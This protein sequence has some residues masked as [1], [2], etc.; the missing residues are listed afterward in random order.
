M[1]AMILRG[2]G[3]QCSSSMKH[4]PLDLSALHHVPPADRT[5]AD[6]PPPGVHG[7]AWHLVAWHLQLSHFGL[8]Q[9]VHHVGVLSVGS[10]VIHLGVFSG[11]TPLPVLVR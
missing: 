5:H 4:V 1:E 8:L 7:C 11:A 6:C 9:A 10:C 3:R 2:Q